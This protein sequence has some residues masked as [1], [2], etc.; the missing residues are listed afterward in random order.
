[1]S[2]RALRFAEFFAGIGLVR[3]GLEPHGWQCVFANDICPKKLQTYAANFDADHF[4]LKD[5][6][7]VSG[8]DIDQ[9]CDL[10]TASFPCVDLSLAGN[11][12]GLAGKESGTLIAFLNILKQRKKDGCLPR[13]VLLENVL[14][15]LSSH[16][17][18]DF[19][20]TASEL[21][22]LGYVIDA[23]TLDARW[24][25]AQSRPRLFVVAFLPSL[26]DG[27][28]A[29]PADI[30]EHQR[31]LAMGTDELRSKKL[32]S[33]FC[34]KSSIRWGQL[35]LLPP[36]KLGHKLD[37]IVERLPSTDERWWTQEKVDYL[38][39]QMSPLHREAINSTIKSG[40]ELWGTIYRRVRNGTTRAELRTD[41]IAGCLRTPR[42]G[43]SKQI[44]LRV[45]KSK[46]S[47]RW[48][49][50]REYARLQGLEDSYVLPPN[51]LQAYFGLGDAVCV[52]AIEWIALNVI[53]PLLNP[54]K[55]RTSA[56]DVSRLN[57]LRTSNEA[58]T[59]S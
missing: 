4:A 10:F 26:A 49:T 1:M 41:G 50:P 8:E 57:Q 14:G 24:F 11:R 53:N 42:G 55:Q 39:E 22:K 46:V 40:K 51:D 15:F 20:L 43:S 16:D 23:F 28:Y 17:G 32:V 34:A 6:W 52:P 35:P 58:L 36:K 9:D 18:K 48:M 37:E 2:K 5:I 31:I 13:L 45:S 56:V 7:E 21:T 3:K 38:L 47:A 30:F 19:L 25:T 29:S 12:Q 54:K 44:I 33:H 27:I 59:P